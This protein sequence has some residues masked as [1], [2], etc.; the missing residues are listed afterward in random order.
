MYRR[1]ISIIQDLTEDGNYTIDNFADKYAVSKQTIRNDINSINQF[2][3]SYNLSEIKIINGQ[4]DKGESLIYGKKF[5][6]TYIKNNLYSYK[7]SKEEL[8]FLSSVALLYEEDYITIDEISERLLV[9]RST[10]INN[11][12]T[13]KDYLKALGLHFISSSNKGIKIVD[14]ELARREALVKM[15][16]QYIKENRFLLLIIVKNTMFFQKDYR[17]VIKRILNEI[18]KEY[19]IE[20]N[21]S[22]YKLLEYYLAFSVEK[23]KAGKYVDGIIKDTYSENYIIADQIIKRLSHAL[24]IEIPDQETQ[25]VCNLYYSV[26]SYKSPKI[27]YKQ[28]LRIQFLARKLIEDVSASLSIDFNSNYTLFENLSNHLIALYSAQ[29][30]DDRPG[31][32]LEEIKETYG[33]VVKEVKDHL[34][35][36]ESYFLR[37]LTEIEILYIAVHFCAAIEQYKLDTYFYDAVLVSN[38]GAGALELIRV[39]LHILKNLHIARVL[40]SHELQDIDTFNEDIL[41]STEPVVNNSIRTVR[42]SALITEQD[43]Q[44]ISGVLLDMMAN[45][46]PPVRQET[47]LFMIRNKIRPVVYQYVENR[48]EEAVSRISETVYKALREHSKPGFHLNGEALSLSQLCIPQLIQLGINCST[49]Q[50]AIRQSTKLLEANEY[51]TPG[52]ADSIIEVT[53]EYGPYYIVA[54][55]IAIA[56]AN[57]LK[58]C[59]RPG[60]S[61]TRLKCGVR[62]GE[63]DSTLVKYIFTLS[64]VDK[65]AHLNGLF[66]LHNIL[67][68][69]DF[70]EILDSADTPEEI[71][72]F[73]LKT[74]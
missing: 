39:K 1:F 28:S 40:N 59:F 52:Y 12:A 67:G 18:K 45:N 47:D 17:P 13:L 38:A 10:F 73:I 55:G 8:V 14:S 71:Y 2:L 34:G 44:A 65:Q 31:L 15:L 46:I 9:S 7:F 64:A 62:F 16:R 43:I 61:F 29:Q 11:L 20:L 26:L 23:M 3:R 27:N 5:I 24:E 50:D 58:N 33:N 32:I 4:I 25:F 21:D 69:P 68:K 42:V 54:P 51:V 30:M 70:L 19:M 72:T 22:S 53:K 63:D 35:A 66:Q 49:W 56:H 57:P 37:S 48:C 36:I 60:I 6:N 41:I 74:C